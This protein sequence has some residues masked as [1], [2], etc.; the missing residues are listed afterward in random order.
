MSNICPII[1]SNTLLVNIDKC[2]CL[3]GANKAPIYFFTNLYALA[4]HLLRRFH[5][6]YHI[7]MLKLAIYITL[8]VIRQISRQ[9]MET[10]T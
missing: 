10:S 1:F 2:S 5:H 6:T 3:Y 4:L 9:A 8:F 7:K